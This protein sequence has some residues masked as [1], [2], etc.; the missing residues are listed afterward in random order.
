MSKNKVKDFKQSVYETVAKDIIIDELNEQGH[1]VMVEDVIVWALE[2]YADM[3]PGYG[4]AMV[5]SY[6]VGRIKEEETKIVDR[7]R[8]QRG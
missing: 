8:W 1:P 5:A 2:F 3:K 7:E 6:I 4:G